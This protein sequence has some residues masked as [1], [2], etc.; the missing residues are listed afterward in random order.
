MKTSSNKQIKQAMSDLKRKEMTTQNT[1]MCN[2][3]EFW[4]DF[5]ARA[6]LRVQNHQTAPQRRLGNT[7]LL[8]GACAIALFV[9]TGSY[10][11]NTKPSSTYS[12]IKS[13]EIVASHSAVLIMK[14]ES[15][16]STMLW[17]VD[18]TTDT[19]SGENI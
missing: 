2:A 8:A 15:R 18:M 16:D 9:I 10:I 19:S 3:D 17:I 7:W 6:S 12:V 1:E 11:I 5:K 4:S 13:L 14:D